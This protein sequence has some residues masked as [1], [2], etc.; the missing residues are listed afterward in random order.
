MR[1]AN[2]SE[3]FMRAE[4]LKEAGIAFSEDAWYT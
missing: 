3:K 4:W 1:E 2:H